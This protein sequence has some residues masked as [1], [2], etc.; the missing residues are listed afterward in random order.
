VRVLERLF[1]DLE[2]VYSGKPEIFDD[3]MLKVAEK[4]MDEAILSGDGVDEAVKSYRTIFE[5]L[6]A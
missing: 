1:S 3:T 4:A 5:V 6:N 2:K